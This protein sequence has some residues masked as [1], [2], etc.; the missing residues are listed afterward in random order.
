MN[1]RPTNVMR[2]GEALRILG[3]GTRLG[4]ERDRLRREEKGHRSAPKGNTK[5]HIP[6]R[7]SK[8]L[9]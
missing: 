5:V 1:D 3:L 2:P 4:Q 8:Y 7:Q 6:P 9:R